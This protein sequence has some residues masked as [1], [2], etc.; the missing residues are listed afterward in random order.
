MLKQVKQMLDQYKHFYIL[1]YYLVIMALYNIY[2]K[3][4][5]PKYYMH[6]VIDDYIP[7]VKEM[8]VP[9]LFWYVYIIIALIYLGFTAKKDFYNLTVFM[10]AGMTISFAIF[11]IFP[12]GQNLRPV[13]KG[14][15]IFSRMV[16][17][18]YMV[19]NPTNSAPSM[20]VIDAIAVHAAVINCSALA[21]KYWAKIGSLITMILII[22]STVMV[23]QHSILDVLYGILLS[24]I[25]YVLIY[26]LDIVSYFIS[27]QPAGSREMYE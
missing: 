23:K 20:H 8:I 13:I 27:D 9:Y 2:N 15:D 1:S 17:S 24:A 3:I 25:L 7:F 19:D 18:I 11:A 4:T 26:K 6:S 22:L 21:K 12:N 16:Q 14:T 10:F 5:V